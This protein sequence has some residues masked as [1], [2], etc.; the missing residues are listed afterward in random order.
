[1]KPPRIKVQAAQLGIVRGGRTAYRTMGWIMVC[2][3]CGDVQRF[4]THTEAVAA[5]S[6]H[7]GRVPAA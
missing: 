7:C 4:A 2:Q 1:V 5:A 6:C 3:F